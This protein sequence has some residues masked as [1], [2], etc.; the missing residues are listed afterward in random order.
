MF[1]ILHHAAIGAVSLGLSALTGLAF[2]MVAAGPLNFL[3]LYEPQKRSGGWKTFQYQT[4]TA[5]RTLWKMAFALGGI[6]G[7]LAAVGYAVS[8]VLP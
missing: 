1:S 2:Y 7:G 3:G 8:T 6:V 5:S 4:V